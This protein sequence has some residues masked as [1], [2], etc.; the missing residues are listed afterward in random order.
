MDNTLHDLLLMRYQAETRLYRMERRKKSLG[1][2]IAQ[3]RYDQRLANV[4]AAEYK[5]SLQSF[6]HRFSGKQASRE[7]ELAREKRA[8]DAR[9]EAL[10]REQEILRK[11]YTEITDERNRFPTREELL[12]RAGD[13]PEIL[14]QFH[15]LE[16]RFLTEQ[17]LPLLDENY[18]ALLEYRDLLQGNRMGQIMTHEQ[19]QAI[20]T[21]PD[22][23]GNACAGLIV[24][25]ESTMADLN[26]P[27]GVPDYY[28]AP[29]A[30][31]NAVASDALRRD[32][33]NQA[34]DQILD[35]KKQVSRLQE[36]LSE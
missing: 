6:F 25:L 36:T 8:A 16:G 24:R 3:A 15:Q 13:D 12:S 32:R 35:M 5:G 11:N 23:T 34:L 21:L 7:E 27:F 29:V 20:C 4:A 14:A 30:Y 2:E 31:I 18:D 1:E 22:T 33:I 9:L 10:L 28:R 26:Q 19:R 17:L